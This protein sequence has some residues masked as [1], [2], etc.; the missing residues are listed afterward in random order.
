[1]PLQ[2]MKN[3]IKNSF[4]Y[5]VYY[6]RQLI[7]ELNF[8]SV[9]DQKMLEFYSQFISTGRLCFDVGANIGNRVKIFLKL[10]LNVVAIEPQSECVK[11]LKKVFGKDLHLKIIHAGLGNHE[12]KAELMISNSSTI[13]SMSRQTGSGLSGKVEDFLNISGIKQSRFLLLRL[14]I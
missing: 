10:Y 8:W 11:I 6:H 1:M 4:L 13:S 2:F 12:G 7:N 3:L 14:I 9:N 5:K